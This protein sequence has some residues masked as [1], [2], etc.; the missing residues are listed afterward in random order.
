MT[1][2]GSMRPAAIAASMPL[3][4]SGAAAE[5]RWTLAIG[6]ASSSAA[7]RLGCEMCRDRALQV[8]ERG[9]KR[10]VRAMPTRSARAIPRA[11][12]D[13]RRPARGRR[14][15]LI[16]RRRS[17]RDVAR[18]GA[19]EQQIERI[20]IVAQAVVVDRAPVQQQHV[21]RLPAARAP[22]S[23]VFSTERRPFVNAIA[24]ISARFTSTRN[25][26][27]PCSRC[28]SR[29][30]R[31]ASSSSSSASPSRPKR[32]AAAAPHHLG[33]RR[34]ARSGCRDWSWC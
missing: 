23:S 4:S 16:V 32:D 33:Q 17:I 11:S 19:R 34:D 1:P 12:P 10:A 3:T 27:P 5:M 8:A 2:F 14:A 13:S 25:P 18:V 15:R 26:V 21:G 31:R 9:R 24:R 29:I 20:E 28:A 6:M 22:P 30:S 7:G